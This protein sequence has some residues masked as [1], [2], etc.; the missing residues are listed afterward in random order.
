MERKV[1]FKQH[2]VFL[3]D[4]DSVENSNIDRTILDTHINWKANDTKG[5]KDQSFTHL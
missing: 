4:T 2:T 1:E 3:F 5:G